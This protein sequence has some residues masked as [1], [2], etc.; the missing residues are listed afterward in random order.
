M[1]LFNTSKKGKCIT[2]VIYSL[3][4]FVTINTNLVAQQNYA[5]RKI[6]FTGNK[7]LNKSEILQKI[8]SAESNIITRYILKKEPT[9]YNEEFVQIDVE[10]IKALYQSQGY[11]NVK[12]KLDS[13]Q[14]NDEKKSV[15]LFFSIIENEPYRVNNV[16]YKL[17][18]K[19]IKLSTDSSLRSA[20]NFMLIRKGTRFI[21]NKLLFDIDK[22]TNTLNN[23]GFVYAKTDYELKLIPDSNKTDVVFNILT[24]K[25]CTIGEVTLVGNK[26]VK[27][28]YI[29][30]LQTFKPGDQFS[31]KPFEKMRKNLYELELF[32]VVSIIPEKNTQTR[33]N[34]I[35]IRIFL[36]EMPRWSAKFNIGWGTEDKLRAS[37]DFTLRSLFGSSRRLNLVVKHSAINPYYASL[38]WIEPHF[39]VNNLSFIVNPYIKKDVEPSYT[40]QVY[41]VNFPISYKLNSKLTTS[42]SYYLERVKQNVDSSNVDVANPENDKFQYNKSGLWAKTSF[43]NA[44]PKESPTK[45]WSLSVA[46]K[47]NGYLLGSDFNYTRIMG[48]I[49]FYQ[50]LGKFTLAER[51]M[52]GTAHSSDSAKFIPVE[53]RFYSGGMNSN[54]G[55]GRWQ[56]GPKRTN[57][58]PLG[59]KSIMEANF[60]VRH[61]VFWRIEIAGFIDASNVWLNDAV[62]RFGDLNVAV[63]G[64]LR[65]NTPIGP[66][67][68]DVGCPVWNEKRKVQFNV[69][70]GQA[71]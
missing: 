52:I 20:R 30:N 64:G 56:I 63:G 22:L 47:L 24:D 1:R 15:N 39:F 61:P 36:Q 5:I 28:K 57:G 14:K 29:T 55:W 44:E 23:K 53:D 7:Q 27:N 41:G 43:S 69:S 19:L 45:G 6:Y 10:Y 54:R 68:F 16:Q 48:D 60:E 21:D 65:V 49:R 32:R 67:R 12:V 25:K 71:F 13:V 51:C 31:N 34:P 33:I 38:M 17:N 26:Y 42:F 4:L 8:S 66:L 40:S 35:P 11:L 70:V 58:T 50:K 59:G 2:M 18:N 3:F 62:Y 37:G 46:A 9:Y